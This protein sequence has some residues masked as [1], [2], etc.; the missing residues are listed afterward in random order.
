MPKRIAPSADRCLG[1]SFALPSP[2]GR[3]LSLAARAAAAAFSAA[4]LLTSPASAAPDSGDTLIALARDLELL[5]TENGPDQPWTLHLHNQGTTPMGVMADPGLLWF[6]IAV[7]GTRTP[8]TCRLPEP[9]WPKG[10]RR[11]A[12]LVLPPG[13]RFSRRFDPRFFCFADLVQVALVPGA[14]VTP[15]FG[16][17]HETRATTVGGKRVEQPLPPRAPFIAWAVAEAPPPPP[18]EEPP[19]VES[20]G[21][22]PGSEPP[23]PESPWQLPDEGLKGVAGTAFVLGP[24]YAKW[25]DRSLAIT[26]GFNVAMLAG[27]DAEDERAAVVTVGIGNAGP[28]PQQAVIRRELLSFD[29]VGP[30]GAFECPAGEMGP[31][32]IASFS[33]LGPRA[34][35]QMVV[36]LI[37]MCA[38]GSFA[39]PGLYEVRATWHSRFSGQAV[40]LEGF[41]GDVTSPRPAIVRVRSGERTSF[42]RAAPMVARGEG[43]GLPG[44]ANPALD[45]T[46]AP[47]GAPEAPADD[48]PDQN[49][50][51]PADEAPAQEVP[52]PEGTSVE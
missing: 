23:P 46:P 24:A 18:E 47:E 31:P 29:V 8:L 35:E 42:L 49:G 11:R 17:S 28:E 50:P 52:A 39:R 14:K 6:E 40:G 16:W 21:E 37:E 51:P 30:D 22:E 34:A 38:R 12:E 43:P 5:I 2:R 41:V 13:E 48:G 3:G 27:S 25:S 10:M 45:N 32:D 20:E 7:P 9:L 4:A 33:S 36:R 1:S 15:H 26:P 44:R 19:S